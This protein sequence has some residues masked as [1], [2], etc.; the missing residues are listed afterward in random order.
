M[1]RFLTDPGLCILLEALQHK[2][3]SVDT[4]SE[5]GPSDE[6]MWEM[7]EAS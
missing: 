7:E 5:E 4:L 1:Y 2:A 3:P 6:E